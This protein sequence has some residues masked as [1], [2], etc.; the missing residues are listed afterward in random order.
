MLIRTPEVLPDTVMPNSY[1]VLYVLG[2]R[3]SQSQNAFPH[4]QKRVSLIFK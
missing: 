4:H 2:D 1:N 3:H